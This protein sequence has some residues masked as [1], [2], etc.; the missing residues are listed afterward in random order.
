MDTKEL[1]PLIGPTV[2]LGPEDMHPLQTL[3]KDALVI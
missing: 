3:H 1:K 2:M